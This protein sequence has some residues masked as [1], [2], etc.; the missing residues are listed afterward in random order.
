VLEFLCQFFNLP[1][2]TKVK[3]PKLLFQ[4]K[5]ISRSSSI[6]RYRLVTYASTRH[7]FINGH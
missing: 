4:Q 2:Q 3:F 6:Q 5:N 7:R 1:P